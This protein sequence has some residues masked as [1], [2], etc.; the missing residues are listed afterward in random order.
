MN[1]QPAAVEYISRTQINVIA[2]D[3]M[4]LGKVDVQ[5]S[6]PQGKSYP[7]SA[8]KLTAAPAFFRFT[9]AG[10]VYV[11]AQHSDATLVA[12]T[13]ALGHPAS[14]GEIITLYAT[15]FGA[16]APATPSG[17]VVSQ[18]NPIARPVTVMIGGVDA[19]VIY[20]GITEA[21]LVQ[22]NVRIPTG[23]QV[24]DQ[25]VAANVAGFQ[26]ASSALIPVGN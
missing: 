10:T 1:G 6:T 2:P 22:I 20:A 12:K 15:G 5:V 21:G 25:T 11:V 17:V 18:P 19:D 9:D 23:L 4:A 13:P 26:T 3:D 24:G 7:G 16:T 14:P 8:S